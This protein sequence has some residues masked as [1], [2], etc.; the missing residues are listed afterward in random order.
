M[1]MSLN[2]RWIALGKR[3]LVSWPSL[4]A[5][6]C[7]NIWYA[8]NLVF[9]YRHRERFPEGLMPAP[10]IQFPEDGF[11]F[12]AYP[13]EW[14][15][16]NFIV[17]GCFLSFAVVFFM[18]CLWYGVRLRRQTDA[19]VPSAKDPVSAQGSHRWIRLAKG[20]AASWWSIGFQVV[21]IIHTMYDLTL[22]FLSRV[23]FAKGLLP[24]HHQVSPHEGG[25]FF[26]TDYA[27]TACFIMVC[28]CGLK[29]ALIPFTLTLCWGLRRRLQSETTASAG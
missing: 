9:L 20:L 24:P 17:L 29:L 15:M 27:M 22:L 16:F 25:I 13:P 12:V 3:V 23:L 19:R 7:I 6:L 5:L 14:I 18:I 11:G 8:T 4:A 10:L 28:W 26:G 21:V 2:P 1:A